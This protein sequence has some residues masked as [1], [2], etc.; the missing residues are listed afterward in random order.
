MCRAPV[1]RVSRARAPC[2]A[3]SGTVCRVLGHRVSRIWPPGRTR[4]QLRQRSR[5]NVTRCGGSERFS[6]IAAADVPRA[7]V[8]CDG[9]GA[10]D[11][12][13][14]PPYCCRSGTGDDRSGTGDGR[15]RWYSGTGSGALLRHGAGRT[16]A[17][18]RNGPA[19]TPGPLNGVLHHQGPVPDGP[20]RPRRPSRLCCSARHANIGR[21]IPRPAL[22]SRCSWPIGVLISQ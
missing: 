22:A 20:G 6:P 21:V 10:R 11:C 8:V 15:A 7:G 17:P 4:S 9:A 18:A 14:G 5:H 3:C 2:V 12:Q 1:P 13:G 16:A 19:R